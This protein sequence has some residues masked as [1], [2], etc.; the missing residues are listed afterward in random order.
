M[1]T[2]VRTGVSDG[3]WIEVTNR[4]LPASEAAPRATDPWVP[5]DGTEQVIL[6]DLSILADGAPVEVAPATGDETRERDARTRSVDGR[7]P[8]S[9]DDR[10]GGGER[11]DVRA[12]SVTSVARS[13][14]LSSIPSK[15]E[16]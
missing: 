11:L 5:I 13:A 2:E 1:R 6:G 9:V 16:E 14:G 4:Q 3:E 15:D 12:E 7:P 8:R 10:S